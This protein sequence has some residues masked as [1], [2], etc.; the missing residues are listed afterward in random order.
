[1]A[2]VYAMLLHVLEYIFN[3]VLLQFEVLF[4]SRV[5]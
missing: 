5:I 4:K 1:M 3:E 2:V